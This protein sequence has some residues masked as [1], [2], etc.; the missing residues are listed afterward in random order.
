MRRGRLPVTKAGAAPPLK[1]SLSVLAVA[2]CALCAACSSDRRRAVVDP[3]ASTL[4]ADVTTRV[5]DGTSRITITV[6]A[7]TAEGKPVR[8]RDVVLAV[9]GASNAVVQPGTTGVDGAAEGS[10]ASTRAETK[11]VTA[12][13]EPGGVT[14]TA[15]LSLDFLADATALS[16]SLS[17]VTVTPASDVVADGASQADVEVVVR[18]VN[19][20]VVPGQAVLLGASGTDNVFV[21]PAG[22]TDAAGRVTGTLAST[23]AETK[24]V[25][26]TVNP[27]PDA[28]VLD[29]TPEVEFVADVT[30]IG[31]ATSSVTA[32]PALG[33]VADGVAFAILSVVV[34]DANGNPVPGQTVELAAS[35]TANL[36][37]Q[38]GS[39][40]NAAGIA[41]ALLSS[42]KA[43]LKTVTAT[44]NPG[45]EAVTL[46]ANPTVAFVGDAAKL[47][48]SL[49]TLDVSPPAGTAAD[50]IAPS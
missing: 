40:T 3:D 2:L 27:G 24:A 41:N 14:L 10:L 38:P 44:V 29:S 5:A 47:S 35:G 19:G 34:R 21:Q 4:V 22:A 15:T 18:D 46:A 50:G 39:V 7:R 28:V 37:T 48:A 32:I 25:T 1:T 23:H 13:V 45:P 16:T 49:S 20:N 36:V 8:G 12:T 26:A 30:T 11:R 6:V 9:S 31:A 17:S 43:E 33:V 42:T